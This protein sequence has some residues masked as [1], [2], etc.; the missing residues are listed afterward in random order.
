MEHSTQDSG[1]KQVSDPLIQEVIRE[2]STRPLLTGR[3]DQRVFRATISGILVSIPVIAFAVWLPVAL[4]RG[5]SMNL[6]SGNVIGGKLTQEQAKAIDFVTGA[7]IG[8]LVMQFLEYC[9]F[10]SA[11]VTTIN[12]IH[13]SKPIPLEALV[14]VST[15]DSGT[16]DVFKFYTLVRPRNFRLFIFALL[17]IASGG[18]NTAFSNIIAYEAFNVDSG[19]TT[20]SLQQLQSFELRKLSR[21][22]TESSFNF[23]ASQS[24]SFVSQVMATLSS[25]AYD[26]VQTELTNSTYIGL[27]ATSSSLSSIP[28]TIL[29]LSDVPSH[30]LSINCTA[31]SPDRISYVQQGGYKYLF[32]AFFNNTFFTAELPGDLSLLQNAYNDQQN[33][34]AFRNNYREFYLA[35]VNSF[36][37]SSRAPETSPYGDVRYNSYNMSNSGFTGTK[38]IMSA[39]GL[40]CN[41][42]RKPGVVTLTRDIGRPWQITSSTFEEE[43]NYPVDVLMAI[44][45][46]SLN[47]NSPTSRMSGFGPA[48]VSPRTRVCPDGQGSITCTTDWKQL[49][50]NVL[51]A[52][53][54]V[55]RIAY[56]VYASKY[57]TPVVNT[58]IED[59][60]V[61]LAAVPAEDLFTV[62]ARELQEFYHITYVPLILIVGL[63][64]VLA[65]GV[66]TN[67]LLVSSWR[68]VAL[69]T[70]RELGL[71][72]LLVDAVNG[73]GG[74]TSEKW[75]QAEGKS[76]D[77]LE[78]WGSEVKVGYIRD[79]GAMRLSD[80]GL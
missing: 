7:I 66:I 68:S 10:T 70:W 75:K 35:Y 32:N 76:A 67:W 15:T 12:E 72:R 47:F 29:S 11:H 61:T 38:A 73:I 51:W 27:N 49:T 34:I 79:G 36:N 58:T 14:E 56:E 24:A 74:G 6:L 30:R 65:A 71:M 44:W 4:R 40:R 3:E 52:M 69:R 18:A 54:E 53:G 42:V 45:Q 46:W 33:F 39:K 1:K 31:V 57:T 28:P 78:N 20:A 16:F 48:V 2:P 80:N 59:G 37:L 41:L 23:S 63:A 21:M 26:G 9:W 55:E 5:K 17:V 25:I 8:P 13:P 22:P 62:Q 77:E 43:K 50:D 60:N 64:S 19:I